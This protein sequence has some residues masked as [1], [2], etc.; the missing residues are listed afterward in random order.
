MGLLLIV[1]IVLLLLFIIYLKS[2]NKNMT[3]VVSD[4]DNKKYMVREKN[5]KQQAANLLG[6]INKNIIEISEHMYSEMD[7]NKNYNI[8][9]PYILRLKNGINGIIIRESS[10]KSQYTSYTVNKGEE[11]IFCIRSKIIDRYING[12]SNIH[13][14][15]L[16][17]YVVL[18]EISHIACPEYGH[19]DLFK[20]IFGFFCDV[21]SN[22]GIYK[23]I[24]F[25]KHPTE[26]CGMTITG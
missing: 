5:D 17:M 18:H 3:Y 23:K 2:P 10:E 8:Y 15:N 14:T 1:S 21:A 4:I 16:I 25:D 13:D 20:D 22:I 26:Y 12:N 11:I 6:T 7:T 9:K 19:T 24:N